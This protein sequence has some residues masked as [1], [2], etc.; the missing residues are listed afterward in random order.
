MI[1]KEIP[2]D[3]NLNNNHLFANTNDQETSD[4]NTMDILSPMDLKLDQLIMV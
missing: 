3:N 2:W 1:T 4:V